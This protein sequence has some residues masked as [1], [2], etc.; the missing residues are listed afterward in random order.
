MIIS[1]QN[2]QQQQIHKGLIKKKLGKEGILLKCGF[3]A[4]SAKEE[5]WQ[6]LLIQLNR[7]GKNS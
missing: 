3:K 1:G 4:L 2:L 6:M 7:R 5:Q